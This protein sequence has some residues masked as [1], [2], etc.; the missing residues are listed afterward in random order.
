MVG[1]CIFG[2]SCCALSGGA[3]VVSMVL[4]V[5]I[6][7]AILSYHLHDQFFGNPVNCAALGEFLL[8][9]VFQIFNTYGTV[10]SL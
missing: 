10:K 1:V 8:H 9:A 3:R 6:D 2:C 4:Q 7:K 5:V